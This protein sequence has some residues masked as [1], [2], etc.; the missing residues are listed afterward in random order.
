[1]AAKKS[2]DLQNVNNIRGQFHMLLGVDIGE[3]GNANLVAN[4][5]KNVQ[6]GFDARTA[7]GFT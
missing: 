5:T 7:L 4:R 1:M 2:G 3:N 6:A